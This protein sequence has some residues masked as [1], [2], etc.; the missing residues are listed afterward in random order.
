MCDLLQSFY[1]VIT[2]GL[3]I[4]NFTGDDFVDV[5]YL[6]GVIMLLLL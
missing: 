2:G 1:I 3:F 5:I 4:I 6:V